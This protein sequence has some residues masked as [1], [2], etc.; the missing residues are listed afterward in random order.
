MP[1]LQ[2]LELDMETFPHFTIALDWIP[3]CGIKS[4]N[5]FHTKWLRQAKKEW[6]LGSATR[7]L[8]IDVYHLPSW[9]LCPELFACVIKKGITRSPSARHAG[10]E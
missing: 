3:Q 4:M 5:S 8:R 10:V 7:E 2:R 1:A 6:R 9:K